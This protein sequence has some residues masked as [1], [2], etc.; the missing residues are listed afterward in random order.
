MFLQ[1]PSCTLPVLLLN[2]LPRCLM[3]KCRCIRCIHVCVPI[4]THASGVLS[5]G[6]SCLLR[7]CSPSCLLIEVWLQLART[8]SEAELQALRSVLGEQAGK[9]VSSFP[10]YHLALGLHLYYRL[11]T[12]V[13]DSL[14]LDQ[15][16]HFITGDLA[17]LNTGCD[18]G[19]DTGCEVDEEIVNRQE[20]ATEKVDPSSAEVQTPAGDLNMQGAPAEDLNTPGASSEAQSPGPNE[21]GHHLRGASAAFMLGVF[22]LEVVAH[23]LSRDSKV[24]EVEPEVIRGKGKNVKCPRDGKLGAAYVDCVPNGQAGPASVMLS[25]GWAYTVGDIVDTLTEFCRTSGR[26]AESTYFWICCLCINQQ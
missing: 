14:T 21:P 18:P 26:C 2:M 3:S 10:L 20:D 19:C 8:P 6:A 15:Y 12:L 24:Y 9:C 7:H 1:V 22:L 4:A 16:I 11:L 13:G 23:G 5:N 17:D 25:Y